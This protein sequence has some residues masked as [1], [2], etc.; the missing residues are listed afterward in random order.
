MTRWMML[1]VMAGCGVERLENELCED[2]DD[3]RAYDVD[4]G[5]GGDCEVE[6]EAVVDDR[7][8][9]FAAI[10]VLSCDPN[11]GTCEARATGTYC[12]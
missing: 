5:V 2:F 6:C 9:G 4:V 12:E 1:V 11:A 10:E 8:D 3:T 7:Y